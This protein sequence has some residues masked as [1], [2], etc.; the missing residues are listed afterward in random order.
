MV[1]IGNFDLW[2]SSPDG[3]FRADKDRFGLLASQIALRP[4]TL[5]ARRQEAELVAF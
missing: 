3:A 2:L 1:L 4:G 5:A